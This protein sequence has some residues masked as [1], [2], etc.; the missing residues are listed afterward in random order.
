[1]GINTLIPKTAFPSNIS[2]V[3][4]LGK[5]LA[6]QESGIVSDHVNIGG[7]VFDYAGELE[8]ELKADITDHYTENNTVI[9]DHIALAPVRLV[10]RGLVGEL[11]A[12]PGES[13]INA[14]L[15][16]LQNSL[17]SINSYI[18]GKTPQ[19][20]VKASKAITQ[21]QKVTTQISNAVSK[22]KSLLNF[23]KDGALSATKQAEAFKNLSSLLEN[24]VPF[25]VETPYRKYDNMVIESL[26]SVQPEDSKYLS[27]FTVVLKQIRMATVEVSFV[28]NGAALRNQQMSPLRNQGLSSGSKLDLSVLPSFN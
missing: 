21:V 7:F 24:R 25:I 6:S 1:M 26:R 15:G 13:G 16:G 10:M 3:S 20:I 27:E 17:T 4:S 9:Q 28:P 14:L 23:L 2:S 22:G 8:A 18:G 5:Y 19:A 12:G 11:V